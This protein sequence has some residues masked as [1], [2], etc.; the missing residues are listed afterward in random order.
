[1][2]TKVLE[3]VRAAALPVVTTAMVAIPSMMAFAADESAAVDLSTITNEA[4]NSLKGDM[5]IVIAATTGVAV[6]LIGITVGI[7][8]LMKKLKGLRTTTA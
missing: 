6:S 2:K 8:F 3:K 5:I 7:A 4:V 1:M